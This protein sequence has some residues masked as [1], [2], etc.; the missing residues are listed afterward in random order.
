MSTNAQMAAGELGW[1]GL[2]ALTRW[3]YLAAAE[4]RAN[5]RAEA[6]KERQKESG[7]APKRSSPAIWL[8]GDGR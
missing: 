3:N 6:S 8:G 4:T 2:A 5:L 1:L 7:C